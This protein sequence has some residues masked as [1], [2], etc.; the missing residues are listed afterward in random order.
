MNNYVTGQTIQKLREKMGLTQKQLAQR[1]YVSDKTISK[2]ETG[3][4]LPDITLLEPLAKVCSVSVTELLSGECVTNGNRSGNMLRTGFYVCPV[5]G[6]IIHA[7]GAGA[8]SCC[9]ITL[10]MLLPEASD[11]AHDIHVTR[12][13]DEYH[14]SVLH[15]MEKL[16]YVSF[17]AY[18]TSDRIQL[19]KLYPEQNPEARFTMR[20]SGWIYVYCNRHGLY[21]LRVDRR[22]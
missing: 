8:F 9:G 11:A 17:I 15:S 13:D 4:G 2:W 18:V 14:V 19:V 1:L 3:K 10:P 7:V 16:H 20:G 22:N 12:M 21:R 5:C 6:N